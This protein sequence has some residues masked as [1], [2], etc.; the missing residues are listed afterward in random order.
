MLAASY[1]SLLAP[2]LEIVEEI[3]QDSKRWSFVPV[4]IGFLAGGFFVYIADVA[5]VLLVC[6]L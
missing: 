5:I 2:A 6:S 3:Y 4:G 1:W